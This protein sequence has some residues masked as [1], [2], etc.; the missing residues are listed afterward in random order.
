MQKK[1][2]LRAY[3]G[4]F[5]EKIEHRVICLSGGRET[6]RYIERDKEREM[7][8][9]PRACFILLSRDTNRDTETEI[10]RQRQTYILREMAHP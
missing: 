1:F 3:G 2:K 9:T 6:D 4:G 10:E 7:A 5:L 8:H